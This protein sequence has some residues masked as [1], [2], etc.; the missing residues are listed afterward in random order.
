[1][2]LHIE[3]WQLALATL[4]L[5]GVPSLLAAGLLWKASKI[6]VLRSDCDQLRGGC[7]GRLAAGDKNF[8]NLAE[9]MAA[10]RQEMSRSRAVLYVLANKSGIK[11]EEIE[12][13][14]SLILG[15]AA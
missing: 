10:L 15:K 2:T 11:P 7:Q 13:Q 12:A 8:E 14:V 9:E 6:F 5:L 4:A 3:I 1:M